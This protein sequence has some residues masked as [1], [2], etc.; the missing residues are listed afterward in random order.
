M[1]YKYTS[2]ENSKEKIMEI[3]GQIKRIDSDVGKKLETNSEEDF[4]KYSSP[5]SYIGDLIERRNVLII[6]NHMTLLNQKD[7]KLAEELAKE[8]SENIYS[9][10][11]LGYF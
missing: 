5:S 3:I 4:K 11:N 9:K 7:P 8:L 6:Q 2:Y 1:E 10:N